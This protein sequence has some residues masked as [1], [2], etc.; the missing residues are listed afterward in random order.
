LGSLNLKII[1]FSEFAFIFIGGLYLL[2]LFEKLFFYGA[3]TFSLFL[4]FLF[5]LVALFACIQTAWCSNGTISEN[6]FGRY[7]II[8]PG[9]LLIC[10]T[11]IVNYRARRGTIGSTESVFFLL[12]AVT[13]FALIAVISIYRARLSSGVRL[14]DLLAAIELH[15]SPHQGA[16]PTPINR[17]KGIA[18]FLAGIG[19]FASAFVYGD[20]NFT[21]FS[22]V[23]NLAGVAL[24]ITAR[25]YLQT[26]AASLLI[27]DKRPPVLLLRSFAD[28]NREKLVTDKRQLIDF[29]LETR[30]AAYFAKFGPFIA[31]DAPNEEIV[32]IGAARA[33]LRDSEWQRVVTGWIEQARYIIMIIGQTQ[34]VDW[35]LRKILE[36][37]QLQK[38]IL[39]FPERR[40]WFSRGN[41]FGNRLSTVSRA[42]ENSKWSAS[43][44]NISKP[45]QL[46]AIIFEKDGATTTIRSKIY[47]RDSIHLAAIIAHYCLLDRT[48][49]ETGPASV[50]VPFADRKL[51]ALTAVFVALAIFFN[52]PLPWASNAELGLERHAAEIIR[53]ADDFVALNKQSDHVL[54]ES[55]PRAK[56]LLRVIF[57][58]TGLKPPG[59]HWPWEEYDTIREIVLALSKVGIVYEHAGLGA[60]A[61]EATTE[62]QIN[63]NDIYYAS[64][65]GEFLDTL[66]AVVAIQ[67]D[68]AVSAQQ[69]V[70]T[71]GRKEAISLA[72]LRIGHPSAQLVANVLYKIQIPGHDDDWRRARLSSLNRAVPYVML[73][74]S[75]A[76]S[77]GLQRICLETVQF[78]KDMEVQAQLRELA[79]IFG[80]K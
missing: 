11:F 3:S 39:L 8:L 77:R 5:Y 43:L 28:D 59:D 78:A 33:Q 63:R 30:L 31:V 67:I 6:F 64:E 36:K 10:T 72:L 24:L 50:H 48:L 71:R 17:G 18:F 58:T 2:S 34:W 19:V 35:E 76:D 25:R 7:R 56:A 53:A 80:S 13:F 61:S 49:D 42:F 27:A 66:L 38:L 75:Q 32:V 14:P 57:D 41:D 54:R 51:T 44:S 21:V 73:V 46:R 68:T 45:T 16:K 52:P 9:F 60:D 40:S 79:N 69:A 22:T 26:D 47:N 37:D 74:I 65:I 1:R 70:W 23:A 20:G 12:I 4:A 15:A 55:D 62:R 29:S